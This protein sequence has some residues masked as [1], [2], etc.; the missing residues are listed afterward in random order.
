MIGRDHRLHH[1]SVILNYPMQLPRCRITRWL[2]SL[3]CCWIDSMS[4]RKAKVVLLPPRKGLRSSVSN[5]PVV[6]ERDCAC[7]F[8]GCRSKG[9]EKKNQQVR[10]LSMGVSK[11]P[12]PL[13]GS[14]SIIHCHRMALI[15]VF[16]SAFG[17][18]EY[19]DAKSKDVETDE[20]QDL[21]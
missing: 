9:Q 11:H 18:H 8:P 15:L 19:H 5:R 20:K 12:F 6:D 1:K 21:L 4:N 2:Y 16:S 7:Y 3:L 14:R 13:P 10:L 17:L